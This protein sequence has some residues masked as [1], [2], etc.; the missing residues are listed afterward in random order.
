MDREQYK[1]LAINLLEA[2]PNKYYYLDYRDH[3]IVITHINKRY[4]NNSKRISIPFNKDDETIKSRYEEAMKLIK[5]S[6]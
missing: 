6:K 3:N 5:A 4:N 1:Q 2:I